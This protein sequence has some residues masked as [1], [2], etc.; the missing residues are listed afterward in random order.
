MKQIILLLPTLLLTACAALQPPPSPT[1][2]AS[3]PY[4]I[5]REE[6]PYEPK[7]EDV[8]LKQDGVVLTAVS[9]SERYDMTPV[10]AELHLLGSMPSVCN[11][12]RIKVNPP[13]EQYQISI[14]IYSVA[15]LKLNCENVFQQFKVSLLLGEYSPGQ[16]TVW[17][18]EN[19]A[20]SM[21]SY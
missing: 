21:A 19:F 1:P 2:T 10:R 15:D 18:N 11:E 7:L 3:P 6:N 14:E 17:V 20:G 12:L 4:V 8:S 16:Y 13:N 5:R 9:L